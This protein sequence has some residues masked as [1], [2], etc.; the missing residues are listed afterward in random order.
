M[1]IDSLRRPLAK[2]I[3]NAVN[4][5]AAAQTAQP[6]RRTPAPSRGRSTR[7]RM[8]QEARPASRDGIR[9]HRPDADTSDQ[10]A[11]NE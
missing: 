6:L 11:R 8:N 7:E 9:I 10:T 3:Q 4:T 5:V 1:M 2:G